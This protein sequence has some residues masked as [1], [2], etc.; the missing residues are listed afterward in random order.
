ML[1]ETVYSPL[2][3]VCVPLALACDRQRGLGQKGCTQRVR[4]LSLRSVPLETAL[5]GI[6]HI[7][8]LPATGFSS[9]RKLDSVTSEMKKARHVAHITRKTVTECGSHTSVFQ[10]L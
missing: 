10:S 4:E 2:V 6:R 8:S 7:P 3:L 5:E 9:H 1:L